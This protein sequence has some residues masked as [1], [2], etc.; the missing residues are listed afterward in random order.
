[1]AS[2]TTTG[3]CPV[4]AICFSTMSSPALPFTAREKNRS[5]PESREFHFI[6]YSGPSNSALSRRPGPT[7]LQ[8]VVASPMAMPPSGVSNSMVT[9]AKSSDGFL[10]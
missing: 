6:E 4:S 8:L 9:L 10:R 1:M 3:I 5:S 2:F 7:K